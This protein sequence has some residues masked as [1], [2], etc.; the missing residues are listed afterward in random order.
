MGCCQSSNPRA[1]LLAVVEEPFLGDQQDCAYGLL[2]LWRS[3]E[4]TLLQRKYRWARE[5]SIAAPSL[6]RLSLGS[7]FRLGGR[8]TSAALA[9]KVDAAAVAAAAAEKEKIA[10][11]LL[12]DSGVSRGQGQSLTSAALQFSRSAS[13]L[14]ASG[15]GADVRKTVAAVVNSAGSVSPLSVEGLKLLFP[16]LGGIRSNGA[17]PWASVVA[18]FDSAGG[19]QGI[20]FRDFARALA[21]SCRGT[22]DE[23]RRFLLDMFAAP[24]A[25]RY[26]GPIG[27]GGPRQTSTP[28][29]VA[30]TT[31]EFDELQR[32]CGLSPSTIVLENIDSG[33]QQRACHKDGGGV[34]QGQ[35]TNEEGPSMDGIT[36]AQYFKWIETAVTAVALEKALSPLFLLPSPQ[37]ELAKGLSTLLRNGSYVPLRPGD[38]VYFVSMRWWQSWAAYV[39][40]VPPDLGYP[41]AAALGLTAPQ[42]AISSP[43]HGHA[44]SASQSHK[45]KDGNHAHMNGHLMNGLQNFLSP[46][47]RSNGNANWGSPVPPNRLAAQA[48]LGSSMSKISS[49]RPY[50]IDNSELQGEEPWEV[51]PGLEEGVHFVA[52]GKDLFESLLEWYG[53]GPIFGRKVVDCEACD[54]SCGGSGAKP[55]VS[56]LYQHNAHVSQYP[57]GYRVNMC[58]PGGR[59][60]ESSQ[61]V[62]ISRQATLRDLRLDIAHVFLGDEGVTKPSRLWISTVTEE[63]V[64][65][66]T[67]FGASSAADQAWASTVPTAAA[68]KLGV[69]NGANNDAQKTGQQSGID[70]P[71]ADYPSHVTVLRWRLVDG[72][73]AASL[74]DLNLSEKQTLMLEV[75]ESVEGTDKDKAP[76]WPRWWDAHNEPSH[77]YKV[78]A[79]VDCMDCHGRWRSAAVLEVSRTPPPYLQTS[80]RPLSRNNSRNV[81]LSAA[82]GEPSLWVRVCLR[83]DRLSA[84]WD[85]W[86]ISGSPRI[87]PPR[88]H[89]TP[90]PPPQSAMNSTLNPSNFASGAGNAGGESDLSHIQPL[91]P[92]VVRV[93]STDR[94]LGPVSSADEVVVHESF[95]INGAGKGG[96]LGQGQSRPGSCGIVN[97][98]NSC[99]MSSVVQCLSHT[100]MLRA[101]LLGGMHKAEINTVNVLGTHGKLTEDFASL[102]KQLWSTEFPCVFPGKF[103]RS[104][105]KHSSQF[106]GVDQQDAQEFLVWLLDTIHEDVNRVL[107]KPYVAA[108]DESTLAG[109]SHEQRAREAWGRHMMRAR[110]IIVDIFHGQMKMECKCSS[111]HK[112]SINFDPF[113]SLS[114][115]IP[116]QE[117]RL[118]SIVLIRRVRWFLKS[119]TTKASPRERT[120][121]DSHITHDSQSQVIDA[122][123]V[124]LQVDISSDVAQGA[125][126]MYTWDPRA[127]V[128]VRYGLFLSRKGS[129]KDLQEELGKLCGL[130]PSEFCVADV[131][132]GRIHKVFT[133]ADL[134][135][136]LRDEDFLVAYEKTRP[137]LH[138]RQTAQ[139]QLQIQTERTGSG[140]NRST[141]N[142]QQQQEGD[143][144]PQAP[145]SPMLSTTGYDESLASLSPCASTLSQIS[146]DR[147]HSEEENERELRQAQKIDHA[148]ALALAKANW[149][150]SLRELHVG[151]LV[152]ALDRTDVWHPGKVDKI[153]EPTLATGF[154]VRVAFTWFGPEY[155]EW[156]T[157]AAW[158]KGDLQPHMSKVKPGRRRQMARIPLLHAMAAAPVEKDVSVVGTGV[159]PVKALTP[160][161]FPLL[162]HCELHRSM[163]YLWRLSVLQASRALTGSCPPALI[164]AL[165]AHKQL[166]HDG[167]TVLDSAKVQTNPPATLSFAGAVTLVIGAPVESGRTVLCELLRTLL[168]FRLK[169]AANDHPLDT[170]NEKEMLPDPTKVLE[171]NVGAQ[172]CVVVEWTRP[173][174]SVNAAGGTGGGQEDAGYVEPL[175]STV[176][177][178]SYGK[179]KEKSAV[180]A[181]GVSLESCLEAFTKE[182]ALDEDSWYCSNCKLHRGASIRTELWKV[183]DILIIHIKRFHHSGD[184]REKLRT[185]V[186]FPLTGLNMAPFLCSKLT[187]SSGG[188]GAADSANMLYDLY[189]VVNH[190]GGLTG[191]HYTA[192]CAVTPC[193]R[194]GSEEAGVPLQPGRSERWI[195]YDDEIIEEVAPGRIIRDA[196]YVLFYRRRHLTSANLINT[197]V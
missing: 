180:L 152:D 83:Q 122:T 57:V 4:V 188:T 72:S 128:P 25:Q 143:S 99:Y 44:H 73:D 81:N 35:G 117:Y 167:R 29:A 111:C 101:Y 63:R 185:L 78:G 16:G 1:A 177:D 26:Y 90:P 11:D 19:S 40:L 100:P 18:C 138:T 69:D 104:L 6:K 20:T 127:A 70:S 107:N 158:D 54:G 173:P 14:G 134:L 13:P 176:D 165:V 94:M 132:Q 92:Q 37:Q 131:Y 15:E 178:E 142:S 82:E 189:S 124:S 31:E 68:K 42:S 149:P 48:A 88:S 191:G 190:K 156:Y 125:Q 91:G 8:E 98:G 106:A 65:G 33:R 47:P 55:L 66:G 182:D 147:T 151:T 197:T 38:T 187:A 140:S 79:D 89:Y 157:E 93:S 17:D 184:H 159:A 168:P 7:S 87:A 130:D 119:T 163:C 114:V 108:P 115:P 194:T 46:R 172:S 97:M 129:V 32:W 23:R 146:R 123:E 153:E 193:D 30:L 160:F 195:H 169:I 64:R 41:V 141:S 162:V 50:E 10:L 56:A 105:V 71:T 86:Y 164:S 135:S 170:R 61:L 120:Q 155:N 52:L 21:L 126:G 103:K 58:G 34:E 148:E 109:M 9:A 24:T 80:T 174:S 116:D 183:P 59:P 62:L 3:S 139:G 102:L 28:G 84:Q 51:A 5:T 181:K 45:D 75:Q 96:A 118:L 121:Q 39:S 2:N 186:V 110:S 171:V 133:G 74:S 27:Q 166:A 85:E 60:G 161:G 192:C 136:R 36:L 112:S 145:L 113:M 67:T 137:P 144:I 12:N 95:D 76:V 43:A 49:K 175:M 53:G 150:Q 179:L 196:A 77:L 22:S 154:R